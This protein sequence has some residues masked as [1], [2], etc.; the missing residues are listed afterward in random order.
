M[1][2]AARG[3][4]RRRSSTKRGVERLSP[5]VTKAPEVE[6]PHMPMTLGAGLT[7]RIRD[8]NSCSSGKIIRDS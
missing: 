4:G 6:K 8:D 3:N 2:L 1:W 5:K 7:C